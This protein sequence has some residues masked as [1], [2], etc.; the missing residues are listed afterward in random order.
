MEDKVRLNNFIL[1]CKGW[2][3]CI[4]EDD[5]YIQIQ[6]ILTLDDYLPKNNPM[7]IV[8][9]YLDELIEKQLVPPI[10]LH[11]WQ[12]EIAKSVCL[13]GIDYNIALLMVIKYYFA[14]EFDIKLNPP[15]YSR[16]LFKMG[17]VAPKH[18]GN[19]YKMQ[20]HKANK[21]FKHYGKENK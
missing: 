12:T 4:T 21:F 8:L 13:Y 2:Y 9:R 20:N 11:I 16:K 10:K 5:I 7:F 19:S 17:F 6:K 15:T 1:W 18:F 14:F 3:V